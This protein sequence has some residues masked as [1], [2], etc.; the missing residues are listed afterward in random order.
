MMM[1]LH[2]MDEIPFKHV[3]LHA[4]VRDVKGVNVQIH[5]QRY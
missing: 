4:L 5:R 3:Y 2:F 1:G